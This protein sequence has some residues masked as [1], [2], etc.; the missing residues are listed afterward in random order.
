L[1]DYVEAPRRFQ[2]RIK[3]GEIDERASY[4]SISTKKSSEEADQESEKEFS[5]FGAALPSKT[6]SGFFL[7]ARE[8][9]Q[10]N[11]F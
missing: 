8:D 7:E 11:Y 6:P 10:K 4:F 9:L 1:D 5:W 3:K 2:S